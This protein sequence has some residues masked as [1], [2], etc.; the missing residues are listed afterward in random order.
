MATVQVL[1]STF[2]GSRF[3]SEQLESIYC[4]RGVEVRLLV[5]DD[6]STDST[7]DILRCEQEQ[8]RLEWY[9]GQN[10]KPARSFLNLLRNADEGTDLYA[11]S[12]Q[13]D[14]W[15]D[16]KLL[17]ASNAIGDEAKPALYFCQTRL[18]DEWLRDLPQMPI[19]PRLT[20]GEA[21]MYQFVGGC[22][23]VFNQALRDIVNLYTPEYLRMHDL[24]VYDIALAVGAK[25]VFDPVPH[26][27]YRQ[28][29]D[30]AIGQT[31]STLSHWR[32]RLQR[33]RQRE[34]IR[35]RTAQE[36]LKGYSS[37]MLPENRELT[38]AIVGYRTSFSKKLSLLLSRRLRPANKTIAFT[39]KLAI[40]LN[41]F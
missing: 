2:N 6:G 1:M 19:S 30:N 22:T 29:S 31:A 7:A 18:V 3:L 24:W 15:D 21:L 27:R 10:L 28:H 26:I 38:E 25:V 17:A 12:D 37:L 8:G 13:D 36:L 32:E 20:Y 23:M 40:L 16:D 39:G 34:H 14:V 9:S 33:L 4:Q 35:L 5:R 11:F 41:L